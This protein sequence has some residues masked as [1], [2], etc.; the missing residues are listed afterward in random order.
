MSLYFNTPPTLQ[1]MTTQTSLVPKPSPSCQNSCMIDLAL[2]GG[3]PFLV[4]WGILFHVPLGILLALVEQEVNIK[5]LFVLRETAVNTP[6]EYPCL[7]HVP[8]V[9]TPHFLV[10]LSFISITFMQLFNVLSSAHCF[11]TGKSASQ[12]SCHILVGKA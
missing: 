9:N 5:T 10:S 6:Y 1:Y 2:V 4:L 3:F 11:T 8:S 7:C 12:W